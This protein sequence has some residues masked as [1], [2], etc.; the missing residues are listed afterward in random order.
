[1]SNPN[2]TR[3]FIR[4]VHISKQK[5]IVLDALSE[6]DR[7]SKESKLEMTEAT[8]EKASEGTRLAAITKKHGAIE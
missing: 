5:L 6:F 2:V 4:L 7:K 3:Y 8:G 1:M